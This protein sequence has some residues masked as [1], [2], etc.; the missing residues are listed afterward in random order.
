[1]KRKLLTKCFEIALEYNNPNNHPQWDCYKH[2]SFII[3]DNKII[4]WGTNKAGTSWTFLGYKPYQKIHSEPVAY[5]RAKNFLQ[6]RAFEVVNI[7]LSKSGELKIA[8]PCQCCATFLKSLGCTKIWFTTR[9][10][11]FALI[12]N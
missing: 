9:N 11:D 5:F 3:Q 1:M 10:G 4:T 12:Q 6:K 8:A 2:F 7:R